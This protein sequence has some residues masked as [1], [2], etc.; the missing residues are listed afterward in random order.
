MLL[1]KEEVQANDDFALPD[2]PSSMFFDLTLD[3]QDADR[4]GGVANYL[5]KTYHEQVSAAISVP[6]YFPGSTSANAA[7]AQLTPMT[8]FFG[9]QAGLAARKIN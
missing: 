4:L 9:F 5:Y 3:Y 2:L 6:D 1:W 7:Q 8:S